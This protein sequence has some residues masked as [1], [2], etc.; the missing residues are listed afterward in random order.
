MRHYLGKIPKQPRTALK[1][2]VIMDLCTMPHFGKIPK[3]PR[4]ALKPATIKLVVD[5]I[6]WQN[7]EA[8]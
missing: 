3:Q 4:T 6:N 7:T 8:A 2:N 1:Q 5:W